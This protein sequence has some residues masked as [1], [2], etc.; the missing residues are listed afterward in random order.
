MSVSEALLVYHIGKQ[1]SQVSSC[2]F[3]AMLKKAAIT[4]VNCDIIGQHYQ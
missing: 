3:T 1:K 2:P 4:Q